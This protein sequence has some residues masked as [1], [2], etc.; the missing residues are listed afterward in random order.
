[1]TLAEQQAA[2]EAFRR[3]ALTV[4]EAARGLAQAC[5]AMSESFS[6]M[7]GRFAVFGGRLAGRRVIVVTMQDGK[8][9]AVSV[10]GASDT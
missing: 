10:R 2:L 1:V 5:A 7:G 4:Q 3:G 6:R 9:R 8:T